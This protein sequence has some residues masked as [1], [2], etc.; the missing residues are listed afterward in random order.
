MRNIIIHYTGHT[1]EAWTSLKKLCEV[2]NYP[3][4]TLRNR[5]WPFIYNG[6]Y[7]VKITLNTKEL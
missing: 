6:R 7:F 5:K 1:F 2:H 4:N 3:Y